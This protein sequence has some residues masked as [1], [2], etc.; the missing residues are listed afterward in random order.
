M[1]YLNAAEI[2][3]EFLIL[4]SV[5]PIVFNCNEIW[6]NRASANLVPANQ[7]LEILPPAQSIL[8]TINI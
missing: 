3:A 2:G 6:I 8:N 1:S 5:K 7:S 4:L